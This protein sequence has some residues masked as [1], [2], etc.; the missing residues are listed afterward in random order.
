MRP[1]NDLRLS[2]T[3]L[4]DIVPD[5]LPGSVRDNYLRYLVRFLWGGRKEVFL[6]PV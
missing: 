3:C 5:C 4:D 2:F 6:L 1:K